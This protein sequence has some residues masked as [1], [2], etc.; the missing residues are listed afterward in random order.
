VHVDLL[1]PGRNLLAFQLLNESAAS[2]DL[3]LLPRLALSTRTPDRYLV[4]P[5]PGAANG[6]GVMGFVEAVEFS[7]ERSLRTE[8]FTVELVTPTEGAKIYTTTNGTEPT[9]GAAGSREYTEAITVSTTTP[10]RARAFREGWEPSPS[11]THTYV[12]PSQLRTQSAAPTGLPRNWS[13]GTPADYQVDPEVVQ[14]AK[15]GFGFE[16]ALQSI[17][18]V[19]LTLD[20]ADLWDAGRGMYFNS[21]SVLERAGSMELIRPDGSGFQTNA[22]MRIHGYTSRYHYFTPKHS[23]RVNFKSAFGPAK[24][25]ERVFPDTD[26][27]EFDQLVLRG[28]ST[29]S[30]CVMD[31]WDGPEPGTKRWF[32]EQSLYLRER[33]MKD[34]QLDLGRLAPHGMFVHVCL[35]GL[36]WGVYELT[37]RP[38]DSFHAAHLG[39]DRE[40]FDVLK[41]FAEVQSGSGQA[42]REMMNLAQA[43]F[44]T[45]AAY[46]RIQGND[47]DG[48]RNPA[49]PVYL[50]L[51]DLI[52]YMILHIY[53]SADDWPNHNWWAGRR[54]GVESEGFRF[55]AWDQEIT[56]ISLDY[57]HTSW[58]PLYEDAA[59]FDSPAYLYAQLRANAAFRLR[60]GDRVHKLLFQG[61]LLSPEG[62]AARLE[63]RATEIDH[64]I[65]AE[66]AR[67]GDARRAVPFRREVEWLSEI[68]RLVDE[69][70]PA[71]HDIALARFR[72]VG[73][74]PALEAP[75]F[76][77]P[78]GRISP[79]F[80][81]E[82]TAPSGQIYYTL[83]GSDPR[84][85]TGQR[86]P[87]AILA[88]AGPIVLSGT[89][90][91]RARAQ[92]GASWS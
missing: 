67:W 3:L 90:T 76:S 12:F 50:D 43:G 39:G 57:A 77:V 84:L 4:P 61:G 55:Y 56:N 78:G 40:E 81:L 26:A 87:G 17:P 79:P 48:T 35:N 51:D 7:E 41:D 54:R 37:E 53:A 10:L 31:G 22:G 82:L 5:T 42:W 58:G 46:Q 9:P 2:P 1:V 6:H 19:C 29:D 14:S 80:S 91:V 63:R 89:T 47:P 69:H 62:S 23:F 25:R 28:M 30:W 49:L 75:T 64:A 24:L 83:D 32:R 33:W 20:P 86:A 73:L 71:L 68:R 13:G 85:S 92:S 60:F 11:V 18:T 8:P 52:D 66:S 21:E 74:Y 34:S 38:T 70:W 36:Y 65:V 15:P 45:A 72:R 27:D 88:Q 16:E 59:A 44:A